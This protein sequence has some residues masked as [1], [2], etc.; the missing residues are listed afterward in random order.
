MRVAEVSFGVVETPQIE[1][2]RG[3]ASQNRRADEKSGLAGHLR[4]EELQR[5]LASE[6]FKEVGS[7][8]KTSAS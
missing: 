7:S 5:L 1:E 2:R 8:T 4:V 3:T 6:R